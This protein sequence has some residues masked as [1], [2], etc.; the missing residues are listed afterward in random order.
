MLY[1]L[2]MLYVPYRFDYYGVSI[3][4]DTWEV[5]FKETLLPTASLTKGKKYHAK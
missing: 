1:K 5:G 4:G 2:Y 3:F